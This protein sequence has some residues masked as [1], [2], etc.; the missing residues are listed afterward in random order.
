MF[1]LGH[2]FTKIE[3]TYQS[4]NSKGITK[5][6][7]CEQCSAQYIAEFAYGIDFSKV[8]K[9]LLADHIKDTGQRIN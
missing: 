4:L 5:R 8:D 9:K 6:C 7:T 1:F 2:S 3:N